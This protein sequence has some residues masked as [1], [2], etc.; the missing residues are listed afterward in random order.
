MQDR[1]G[2]RVIQHGKAESLFLKDPSVEGVSIV[3]EVLKMSDGQEGWQ[4][5]LDWHDT[6]EKT[7]SKRKDRDAQDQEKRC[8]QM[9][10][11]AEERS[12][13]RQTDKKDRLLRCHKRDPMSLGRRW[14][15]ILQPVAQAS[16]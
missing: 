15:Q 12:S 16:G 1:Q 9:G 7:E 11:R 13:M 3:D 8:E 14:R 2:L 10:R 6:R 4:V 5:I